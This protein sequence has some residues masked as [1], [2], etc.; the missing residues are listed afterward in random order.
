M[1]LIN[2]LNIISQIT[3]KRRSILY[4]VN[5]ILPVLFFLCLDLAS[6][7][8]SDTGGEKLSFKV[9]VLLAVTVMQLILNDILPCSS[10]KV[11]L[12]GKEM[13]LT[14]HSYSSCMYMPQL[15]IRIYISEDSKEKLIEPQMNSNT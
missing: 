5:F 13:C 14:A 1:Y 7:L 15:I 2:Q 8:I 9:T 12:I 6:F 3:M 11:P 10:N 4:I